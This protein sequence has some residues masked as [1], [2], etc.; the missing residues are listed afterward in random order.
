MWIAVINCVTLIEWI[1]G[2]CTQRLDFCGCFVCR[3]GCDVIISPQIVI[4]EFR[5]MELMEQTKVLAPVV[6]ALR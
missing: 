3:T 5:L 2:L 6:V 4:F 1:L